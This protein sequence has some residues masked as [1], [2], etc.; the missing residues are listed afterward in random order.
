MTPCAPGAP[1]HSLRP[2]V[3]ALYRVRK[4]PSWGA[5]G[6]QRLLAD[7]ETPA[8][9]P[10]AAPWVREREFWARA[11]RAS[12]ARQP[13]KLLCQRALSVPDPF[14]GSLPNAGTGAP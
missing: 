1:R 6:R 13:N 2:R 14:G 7:T 9:V 3:R 4:K 5:D 8:A 11:R 12:K 10:A